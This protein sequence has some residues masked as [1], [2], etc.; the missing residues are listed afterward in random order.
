MNRET[1]SIRNEDFP[2]CLNIGC[3]RRYHR[4]WANLDL[5]AN[6]STVIRH[7]VKRGIPFDAGHF[8]A[9][10]HS[11]VLEHL[12]PEQGQRLIEE[13]FRVLAPGGV[14]RI[15]VPDLERIARLYLETHQKAWSGDEASTV[16]YSW[17]K[18]ELLDQLVREQSGGRMGQYMASREIKNSDFVHSR[19]GD[20]LSVCQAS[21]IS[22]DQPQTLYS[23]F[24]KL[25]FGLRREMARRIVRWMMG[26]SA[27]AAFDEGLFRSQGEVHRWMYDRFSLRELCQNAGFTGFVVCQADESQIGGYAEFEL[28]AVKGQVRKP[29]SIFVEC[30]KPGSAQSASAA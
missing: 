15:V 5:E 3:G 16:D 4:A 20:E 26:Q 28:D 27:E 2:R 6:D 22:E 29:D 14:L 30:R 18:L 17:M 23:R 1:D 8:N 7:D 9:V 13:C 24:T 21:M 10:Y 25:T 11:H 19:V 12:K